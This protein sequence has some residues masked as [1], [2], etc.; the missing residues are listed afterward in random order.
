MALGFSLTH[1]FRAFP[2]DFEV[3]IF[4]TEIGTRHSLLTK[5]KTF[6][7]GGVGMGSNARKLTGR[8]EPV[9]IREGSDEDEDGRSLD[10]VSG[11]NLPN[12]PDNNTADDETEEDDKKKLDF[13]ATYEGFSIWGWV[14]CLLV[15]RKG[16]P[17]RKNAGS[18]P[19]A[20]MAE[21]I[22]STQQFN[23]EDV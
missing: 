6:I 13:K 3:A 21:W 7:E 15:E 10:R 17:G 14:L 1:T 11:A 8:D 22:A 4:L 16:G 9:V 2:D 19:Q 5:T 20:L 12:T 23:D 18:D